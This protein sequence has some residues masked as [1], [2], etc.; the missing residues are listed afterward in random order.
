MY[1]FVDL[2]DGARQTGLFIADG[3]NRFNSSTSAPCLVSCQRTA[4]LASSK[5][6]PGRNASTMKIGPIVLDFNA[7]FFRTREFQIFCSTRWP[8][9]RRRWRNRMLRTARN[10]MPTPKSCSEH[11]KEQLCHLIVRKFVYWLASICPSNTL[12]QFV[13]ANFTSFRL[14]KSILLEMAMY[15]MQ[16]KLVLVPVRKF[17]MQSNKWIPFMTFHISPSCW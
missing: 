16:F 15:N 17:Y 4:R 12:D 11:C 2:D 8:I 6:T 5:S 9:V 10:R 3:P 14:T 13:V 7:I 1:N